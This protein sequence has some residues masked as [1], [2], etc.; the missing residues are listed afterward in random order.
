MRT[1]IS[2]L[3]MISLIACA[4]QQKVVYDFPDAM[5]PNV[6]VEFA[7][8]C[9]KGKILY[10]INCARCHNQKVG[11]KTIIPD[12]KPEQLTGYVLREA[13]VTHVNNLPEDSVTAED[14][15]LIMTFLTYKKKNK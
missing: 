13:N 11:R 10:D 5:L 15:G 4:T 3:L 1:Y 14:L 12:F 8:Q 2:I 6:K 7:K 9:D